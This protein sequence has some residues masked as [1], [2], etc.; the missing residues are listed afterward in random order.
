MKILLLFLVM[1]GVVNAT[2]PIFV[3]DDM[4]TIRKVTDPT[5]AWSFYASNFLINVFEHK[6]K[7]DYDE[8]D[9]M[10]VQYLTQRNDVTDPP[11][12]EFEILEES[13]D[14]GYHLINVIIKHD[15]KKETLYCTRP[16]FDPYSV[17]SY[18]M[19]ETWNKTAHNR[20]RVVVFVN[21]EQKPYVLA[22]G[23]NEGINVADWIAFT[24]NKLRIQQWS[25]ILTLPW[26]I[27]IA[28]IVAVII[29][30]LLGMDDVLSLLILFAIFS[31]IGNLG[32][33][34]YNYV[35]IR[36]LEMFHCPTVLPCLPQD[37]IGMDFGVY[38]WM[39]IFTPLTFLVL[40]SIYFAIRED[41]TDCLCAIGNWLE[42]HN[43]ID[44]IALF[45]IG[46]ASLS[47]FQPGAYLASFWIFCVAIIELAMTRNA[48]RESRVTI[49]DVK[50]IQ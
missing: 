8:G 12:F 25:G 19:H 45:V 18:N 7:A 47:S 20:T 43:N 23:T 40:L 21:H 6:Y 1:L 27:I 10:Q 35:R 4:N 29:F 30:V 22:I 2:S 46:L 31:Y 14:K 5:H 11:C 34:L 15:P 49:K 42:V 41:R 24:Y 17:S 44:A 48:Y 39:H 32:D 3:S 37:K 38:A 16:F 26:S 28:H 13:T 50:M 33:M 36:G 9:I